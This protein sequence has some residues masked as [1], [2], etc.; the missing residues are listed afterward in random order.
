MPWRDCRPMDERMRFVQRAREPGV[1]HAAA[2]AEFGISRKTGYKWLERFDREGVAGLA[3]RSRAPRSCPH[4]MDAHVEEVLLRVRRTYPTWGARKIAAYLRRTRPTFTVPATSSIHDALVRAGLVEPRKRRRRTPRR[5][6]P[7][8]HATGPN[9]VWSIDYKGQ[10]A[11]RNGN[12]CYPLTITD[13]YSR[14]LLGCFALRSTQGA[15]AQ[16]CIQQCFEQYGLPV[17]LRSDNGVPFAG[18]GISGLSALSC[19]WLSLGVRSERIDPGRPDQNGRHERMHLTLKEETTRPAADTL[20]AQQER[21]DVFRTYYNEVR[22][23]EGI[24]QKLPRQMYEVSSRSLQDVTPY[25]YPE[26][27]LTRRVGNSG[28]FSFQGVRLFLSE[29]LRGQTIALLELDVDLWL[30]HFAGIDLAL[31]EVGDA[32]VSAFTPRLPTSNPEQT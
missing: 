22:P 3:D 17:A 15:S 11:L 6:E 1:C 24:D 23:H 29:A 27:D 30:I 26:F 16:V 21:F 32:H 20:E 4:R 9:E 10:F 12:L 14:M 18:Q 5:T 25:E 28:D 31:F 2:C 19:W 13:N 8:R 7:L